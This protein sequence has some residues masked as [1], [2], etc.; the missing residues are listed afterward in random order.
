MR[1]E[2]IEVFNNWNFS[3]EV[4]E[5][6]FQ[7]TFEDVNLWLGQATIGGQVAFEDFD[8]WM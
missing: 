4:P 2:A 3:L 8:L 7:V 6:A 5:P 1:Q